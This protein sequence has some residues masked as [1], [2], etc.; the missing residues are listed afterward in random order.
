MAEQSEREGGEGLARE[1][2]LYGCA[3]AVGA[4]KMRMQVHMQAGAHSVHV[5]TSMRATGACIHTHDVHTHTCICTRL[6]ILSAHAHLLHHRGSVIC[7]AL[8]PAGWL[9]GCAGA[10]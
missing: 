5:R 8:R 2:G 10:G 9:D 1:Q 7:H 3:G 6:T 4:R